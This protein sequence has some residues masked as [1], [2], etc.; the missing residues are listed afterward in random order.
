MHCIQGNKYLTVIN[1]SRSKGN[2][3]SPEGFFLSGSNAWVWITARNNNQIKKKD[4]YLVLRRTMI[5]KNM[6]NIHQLRKRDI[7]EICFSPRCQISVDNLIKCI[8]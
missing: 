8:D 5:Y 6:C 4:A 2:E 7:W 3:P 1:K